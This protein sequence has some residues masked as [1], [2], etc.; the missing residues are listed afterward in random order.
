MGDPHES[1]LDDVAA[2]FAAARPRLFGIAYR[3]LGSAA[4]AEDVVQE[5][6]LRWQTTDR[7]VV[8]EPAAFLATTATRL[9]LNV[10]QSARARRETYV[11]PWLPEPIDTE[12]DPELGALRGEALEL[13]VLRLLERLGPHERAAYVLSEAFD[14]PSAQIAAMLARSDASVRQLITRARKHIQDARRTP[15]DAREQRRLLQ[16][17]LDAARS[18]D[19]AGL[20]RVLSEDA[21]SISDGGGLVRGV[22]RLPV[23]GRERVVR[24]TSGFRNKTF[25]EGS[26]F[27]WCEA[28]GRPAALLVRD[29]A[30][31]ALVTIA[32]SAAG[33]D[34]VLWVMNPHK[35]ARFGAA[36]TA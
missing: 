11:G 22:A 31:L 10:A 36:R 5:T 2:P 29:G 33:I 8:R 23:L 25:F 1:A 15:V 21:V 4:E 12:G 20:A 32:A 9:A 17:F 13:G 27:T 24:F 3:L 14:Y 26:A 35:L 18:G 6:Y 30:V 28:N 7:S 19:V 16:A 34:E